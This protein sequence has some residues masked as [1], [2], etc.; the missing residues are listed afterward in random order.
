MLETRPFIAYHLAVLHKLQL[1]NNNVQA[2]VIVSTRDF[3]LIR[4]RSMATIGKYVLSPSSIYTCVGG[5]DIEDSIMTL[6]NERTH[7]VIGTPGRLLDL[8][9]HYILFLDKL[10]LLVMD[11]LDD[12]IR[13]GFQDTLQ[14]LLSYIPSTTQSLLFTSS[15]LSPEVTKMVDHLLR[16]EPVRLISA[17]DIEHN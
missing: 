7:I 1:D 16:N 12:L 8:I 4:A 14:S 13:Y 15:P 10:Q 3:A 6:R 5:S 9:E 17:E 2:L 11:D